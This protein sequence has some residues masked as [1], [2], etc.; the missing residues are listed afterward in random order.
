M[1]ILASYA[2]HFPLSVENLSFN[3]SQVRPHTQPTQEPNN[4]K[5]KF[6]YA[7]KQKRIVGTY[8]GVELVVE[9]L[10]LLWHDMGI[11]ANWRQLPRSLKQSWG[12]WLLPIPQVYNSPLWDLEQAEN[13]L[14]LLRC[15]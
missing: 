15:I 12:S 13:G 4:R 1:Q 8:D 3:S 11:S 2:Q 5:W 10:Y 9:K 7:K 14:A 6:T